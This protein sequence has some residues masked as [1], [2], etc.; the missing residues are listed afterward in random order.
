MN[1][2]E[3]FDQISKINKKWNNQYVF[4]CDEK[5][6][7]K[8][9]ID[10]I[11][12]DKE[13]YTSNYLFSLERCKRILAINPKTYIMV[14]DLNKNN[15]AIGYINMMCISKKCYQ[16]IKSGEIPDSEIPLTDVV[17]VNENGVNY[18]YFGSIAV[19]KEYR[20]QGIASSMLKIFAAKFDFL[21]SKNLPVYIIFDDVSEHGIKLCTKLG[22]KFVNTTNRK[23]IIFE[24]IFD[25]RTLF[26]EFIEKLGGGLN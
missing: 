22:L 18:V 19:K 5:V 25:S 12:I 4:V 2:T 1:E 6:T 14:L 15:K 16:Q 13:N 8:N 23:S 7:I 24:G 26:N 10:A 21:F 11:E 17:P 20:H 9:I 3:Y